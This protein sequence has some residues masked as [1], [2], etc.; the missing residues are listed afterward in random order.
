MLRLHTLTGLLALL[1]ACSKEEEEDKS[2]AADGSGGEGGG[3][4]G[5]SGPEGLY[6]MFGIRIEAVDHWRSTV[7]DDERYHSFLVQAELYPSDEDPAVYVAG[8]LA[9]SASISTYEDNGG[10]NGYT[11]TELSAE[12]IGLSL[13]LTFGQ[14]GG[15]AT[16]RFDG[17]LSG[18]SERTCDSDGLPTTSSM[19][20]DISIPHAGCGLPMDPIALDEDDTLAHITWATSASCEE[21]DESRE[22]SA[23]ADIQGVDMP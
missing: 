15:V 14:E 22:I 4:D 6:D 1:C 18:A 7:S 19:E 10:D 17:L 9:G 21:G 20:V 5:G 2:S 13:S 23:S 3:S 16:F 11:C 12:D 8:D